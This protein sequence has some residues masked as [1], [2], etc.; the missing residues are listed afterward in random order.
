M[1]TT[2]LDKVRRRAKQIVK[3]EGGSYRHALKK[4]GAEYRAGRAGK[5][6]GVKKKKEH[7]RVGAKRKYVVH[8]VV[9]KVGKLTYKGGEFKIGAL[10]IPEARAQVKQ[11]LAWE[12]LARE[13]AK[14]VRDRKEAAKR[15]KALKLLDKKLDKV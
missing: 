2:A 12:L 14:N 7:K 3:Y 1:S 11:K 13:S 10:T 9:E 6:S 4:A 15:V 8:H 5:V